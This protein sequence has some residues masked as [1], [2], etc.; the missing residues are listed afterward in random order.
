M[1]YSPQGHKELDTAEAFWHT[2]TSVGAG[3]RIPGGR[4]ENT[5]AFLNLQLGRPGGKKF[6][7]ID[8]STDSGF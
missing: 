3:G 5:H 4:M 2:R 8:A 6:S 1:G 7:T